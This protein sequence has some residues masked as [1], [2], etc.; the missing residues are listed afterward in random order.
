MKVR[1]SVKKI[2]SPSGCQ[3]SA[4]QKLAM[5]PSRSFTVSNLAIRG[6]PR[7]T[8]RLPANGST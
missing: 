3:A 2:C 7:S 8:A 4:R 1:P 5:N 6:A